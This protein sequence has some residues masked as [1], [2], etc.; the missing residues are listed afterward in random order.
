MG[1]RREGPRR[2]LAETRRAGAVED[3]AAD[4]RADQLW[5]VLGG[6]VA[7]LVRAGLASARGVVFGFD[8]VA[9]LV[10]EFSSLG[11]L[12]VHTIPFLG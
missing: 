5:E 11:R 7:G 12:G 4:E 10:E 8:H 6:R 3:R 2:I 9:D 1:L